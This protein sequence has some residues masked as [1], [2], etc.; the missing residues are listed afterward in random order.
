VS[1]E[2]P[3]PSTTG[4]IV[5]CSDEGDYACPYTAAKKGDPEAHPVV[6]EEVQRQGGIQAGSLLSDDDIRCNP[7]RQIDRKM[8]E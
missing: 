7:N 4:C 3:L 2:R 6:E 8:D 5:N 1:E